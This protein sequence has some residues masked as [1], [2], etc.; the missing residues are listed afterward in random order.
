LGNY[1]TLQT[2]ELVTPTLSAIPG[3]WAQ[4]GN[5]RFYD[6]AA[7]DL[8]GDLQD[9]QITA[10]IGDGNQI[11]LSIGEMPGSLGRATSAPAVV[12]SDGGLDLV[13]RG[14]DDALWYHDGASWQNA[15]GR[16][17]SGP[18][19]ASRAAGQFD[20]FAVGLD[21]SVEPNFLVLWHNQW[22]GAAWT[23]WEALDNPDEG[24]PPA[25]WPIVERDVPT[26]ELPAPAVVTDGSNQL[27]LFWRWPD[28]T[29]RWRH[30][31]GAN[32]G[33]WQNQGGMLASGPGA[34]AH[35]GQIDVFARGVDDALWNLTYNGS[36]WEDWQRIDRL[37][38]PDGVTIAS[39]PAAVSPAAGQMLVTVRGSDDR[40]WQLDYDGSSWG[41]W[42]LAGPDRSTSGQAGQALG[43]DGVN[44]YVD[45]PDNFL[46]VTEFTF[47]AWVYWNGG[48]P[49]QRIFDFGQNTNAN[50]FLTPSNGT[51]LR[52]AITTGGG[53][54]EQ[55]L[56]ASIPLTQTE[57]VH[58]AVTLDGSTGVL[59]V[60][61]SAVD[62]QTI[63]LTPQDV[64]GLNTWLGKS[65]YPA[66]P[67]FNGKI[68]EVTIFNRA[69]SA[70]EIS[71]IYDSGWESLSGKI[72]ALH[73]DENPATNG[74]TLAD[75][76]GSGNDGTLYTF[77]SSKLASAPAVVA[78]SGQIDLFAR[79]RDGHL[80]HA[81]Y[82]G[83]TWTDWAN[84]AGLGVSAV[85]TTG[86]W[87]V[88]PP[89]NDFLENLLLDVETG[90]FTGDGRQQT[91]LAYQSAVNQIRIELYDIHDGFVPLKI[92]ELPAPI[93]GTVPRITAADV[94]GDGTDE[95]GIAHLV[96]DAYHYKVE[97][98]DVEEVGGSW[99]GNLVKLPNDSPKFYSCSGGCT[100]WDDDAHW[101][102]GTL[103][104][105]S[106]D[107]VAETLGQ[108]PNENPIN[109]KL[110]K[111]GQS[112]GIRSG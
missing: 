102:A 19:V 51:N 44:D 65:Q 84:V 54:A 53:G 101:F 85:Y 4:M 112:G 78:H 86:A 31:D 99:T 72:L 27:D 15:G 71:T 70:S 22:N 74:T 110:G 16:L 98:Y 80:G 56:N 82:D 42:H 9:E 73:L 79:T 11:Y 106:G 90:Y 100:D 1:L 5:H 33:S 91:V 62:T 57:W 25:D 97:V 39:A 12:S 26:P 47:A 96:D 58:V 13:V 107:F 68:D 63:T 29:L 45:L 92:A 23:G 81:L 87:T 52:F 75:A 83:S 93:A 18:A 37:G 35:D 61:G 40:L 69:L 109:V 20:V 95:I 8:N 38:M 89:G 49:W 66:D 28:N 30:F 111:G 17:L 64:V 2:F 3:S 10:W 14:Y 105:T 7:G 24:S 46:D 41:D 76:S 21:D 67:N 32:W 55:R 36:S 50:M 34:V 6:T 88:A 77:G 94:D 60:N 48:N 108:N 59:Y 104:I 103:R 43:L